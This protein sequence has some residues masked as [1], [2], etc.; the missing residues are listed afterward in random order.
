MT[1]LNRGNA[2]HYRWGERCEGWRLTN[3]PEQSIILERMPPGTSETRHLH[4][5]SR[6]LFFILKG[7]A[8]IEVEGEQHRLAAENALEIPPGA[9]HQIFNDGNEDLEFLLVSQPGTVG[10][11]VETP[12]C[13]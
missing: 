1:V 3:R 13:G 8:R 7:V 10:D 6:Q 9:A 2:P 11:R 4:Q 12:E 5:H